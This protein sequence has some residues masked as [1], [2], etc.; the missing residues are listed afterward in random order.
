MA[1]DVADVADRSVSYFC[2]VATDADAE[3]GKARADERLDAMLSG[4]LRALWPDAFGP[5]R[6]ASDLVV[7]RYPRFNG[8]GSDRYTQSLPKTIASRIS[9]LDMSVL[10]MSVAGDWTSS[11]LDAGCVEA[12]VMS[13]MLAAHAISGGTPKLSDIV[14]YDHP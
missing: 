2:A 3:I 6:T 7:Q 4:E 5:G 12:A 14:G 1:R 11:G 10:N 13:G 8:E 9:P